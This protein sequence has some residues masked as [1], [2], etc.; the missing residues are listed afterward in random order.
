M[1]LEVLSFITNLRMIGEAH[2][3]GQA[4][5]LHHETRRG[6]TGLELSFSGFEEGVAAI[7][8]ALDQSFQV[9]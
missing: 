7:A 4:V 1:K 8:E 9:A 5:S 2:D 6:K 3:K